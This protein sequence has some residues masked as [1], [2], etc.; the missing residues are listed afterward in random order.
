M[1][2]GLGSGGSMIHTEMMQG[3]WPFGAASEQLTS[4]LTKRIARLAGHRIVLRV[5]QQ[6]TFELS[7]MWR[8]ETEGHEEFC[9]G[10][11]G[12][13]NSIQQISGDLPIV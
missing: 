2:L 7:P 12:R 6:R 10:G 5:V 11:P 9:L 4:N 3:F 1:N 13:M 8:R